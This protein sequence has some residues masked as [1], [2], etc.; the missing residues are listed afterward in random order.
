MTDSI[1][2]NLSIISKISLDNKIYMNDEGYLAIENS[3]IFQG[4]VRFVFR[5]GRVKTISN[6]N[7]FYNNVFAY[8]D[9]N[10]LTDNDE[11]KAHNLKTLLSYLRK[12]IFGL[13]NLKETY[14]GDIVTSSK[15]DIILDNVRLYV[16]KLEKKTS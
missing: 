1:L 3:T 8:I 13:E 4:F 2:I 15:L 16:S 6:L 11:M 7:N 9:N 10:M 12:S 5:N 14:N